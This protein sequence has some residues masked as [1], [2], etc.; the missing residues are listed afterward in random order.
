MRSPRLGELRG[1]ETP[2]GGTGATG[3]E[4]YAGKLSGASVFDGP[5][6]KRTEFFTRDGKAWGYSSEAP[7]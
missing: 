2:R 6:P 5:D 7:R 1:I 4:K 3:Y